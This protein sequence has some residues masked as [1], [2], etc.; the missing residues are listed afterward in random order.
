MLKR[1]F[2][3]ILVIFGNFYSK[4]RQTTFKKVVEDIQLTRFT[5]KESNE[6]TRNFIYILSN[7]IQKIE[8]VNALP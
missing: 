6:I 1:S 3:I 8:I 4:T 5:I 2:N 7:D